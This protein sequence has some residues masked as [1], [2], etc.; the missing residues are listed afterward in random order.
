MTRIPQKFSVCF[1]QRKVEREIHLSGSED[2]LSAKLAQTHVALPWRWRLQQW[3][4]VACVYCLMK[5]S[6]L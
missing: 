6:Q 2:D 4:I 1:N 3:P 5:T